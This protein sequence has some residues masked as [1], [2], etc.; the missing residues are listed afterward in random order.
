MNETWM[1]QKSLHEK[2]E[3]DSMKKIQKFAEGYYLACRATGAGGGGCMI[4][5]TD[6]KK[7]L[8]Q[9]LK[10]AN[11][12]LKKMRIIP[13]KIDYDGIRFECFFIFEEG[14]N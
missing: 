5:Y 1:L 6:N 13:F 3:T 14:N 9:R 10:E 12:H 11:G 7:K 4:F 2:M 8:I